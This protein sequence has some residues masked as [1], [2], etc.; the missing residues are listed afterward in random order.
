[1]P[2]T[3]PLVCNMEALQPAERERHAILT[4]ELREH[5]TSTM[6]IDQGYTLALEVDTD[7]FMRLAEWVTLEQRCCPFLDFSLEA[8]RDGVLLRLTGPEGTPEFLREELQLP[9]A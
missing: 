5:C 2:D 9:G 1:M 8:G 3:S 6:A 4:R 7:G